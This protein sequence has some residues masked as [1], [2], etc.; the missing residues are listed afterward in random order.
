MSSYLGWSGTIPIGLHD[1]RAGD[2]DARVQAATKARRTKERRERIATAVLAGFA[3]VRAEALRDPSGR[4]PGTSS[5]AVSLAVLW[6]DAL[7]E[8]LDKEV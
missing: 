2:G 1:D 3:S 6:A 7:I 4:Q 5:A 8:E